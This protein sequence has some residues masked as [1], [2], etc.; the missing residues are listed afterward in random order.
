MLATDLYENNT[1]T[2]DNSS[3][4]SKEHIQELGLFCG[5]PVCTS[6]LA[7]GLSSDVSGDVPAFLFPE[8][9]TLYEPG[10]EVRGF[11]SDLLS[12]R[13]CLLVLP[14]NSS[15]WTIF[16]SIKSR[17][18]FKS[19]NYNKHFMKPRH[20]YVGKLS[21]PSSPPMSQGTGTCVLLQ[22]EG[23]F[24]PPFAFMKI[25]AVFLTGK[26]NTA[27]HVS[28]HLHDFFRAYVSS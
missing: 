17:P 2:C 25:Y 12:R 24:L 19:S 23:G 28:G 1:S 14:H 5:L 3:G 13:F 21:A 6:T 15:S 18:I 26:F 7:Q 9:W 27:L 4:D 22:R 10:C 20:V 16:S 8:F 11:H